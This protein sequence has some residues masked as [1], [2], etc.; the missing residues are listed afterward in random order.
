MSSFAV[1]SEHKPPRPVKNPVLKQYV[2]ILFRVAG[3]DIAD[4]ANKGLFTASGFMVARDRGQVVLSFYS[5]CALCL[6]CR[7]QFAVMLY[8][9]THLSQ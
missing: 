4:C 5:R 9:A 3:P 6:L 1:H 7:F 2:F 8:N